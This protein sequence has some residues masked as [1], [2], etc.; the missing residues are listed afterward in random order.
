MKTAST[1]LRMPLA[2]TLLFSFCLSARAQKQR[3]YQQTRYYPAVQRYYTSIPGP[4]LS[5]NYGGNP[6]YYSAGVFYRP[7]NGYYNVVAPPYGIRVNTLPPAY[8]P[9][10][11]GNKHYY[12]ANG[13]F[14]RSSPQQ[15][16]YEVVQAP[17]GATV[18]FL[19]G[20]AKTMVIDGEKFYSLNGTYF[21]DDLQPNGEQWYKVVG[22]NGVLNT[23][24]NTAGNYPQQQVAPQQQQAY[25]QQQ[26]YPQQQVAPQQSQ[27]YPQQQVTPQQQQAYPQQQIPTVQQQVYVF[28][29]PQVLQQQQQ[30][31]PQQQQVYP[32]QQQQSV[33]QQQQAYPEPSLPRPSTV[34]TPQPQQEYPSKQAPMVNEAPEQPKAVMTAPKSVFPETQSPAENQGWPTNGGVREAIRRVPVADSTKQLQQPQ[35]QEAGE[36]EIDD[37]EYTAPPLITYDNPGMGWV[38][39]RLPQD[40]KTVTI[41]GKKYFIAPNNTYYEEIVD[42]K[43]QVRYKV[44]STN[45]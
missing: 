8:Y 42:E 25:P 18:P 13:V 16:D 35:Q 22:K 3:R 45:R 5:I 33:P 28:P 7:H 34:I 23:Y 9:V 40:C 29:P 15:Q 20:E 14:Y 41:S 36:E 43:R 11:T 2:F 12:Y 37:S 21:K 24:K 10:V 32:Q 31:Y 1:Y 4:Y 26:T 44:V 27:A 39:D 6:Y 38:V 30:A 17:I 19:P